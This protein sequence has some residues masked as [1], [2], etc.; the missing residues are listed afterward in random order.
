MPL[1]AE[2]APGRIAILSQ[3]GGVGAMMLNFLAMEHLGFSK[4]ASIGNKLNVNEVDLLEYL[5]G[6]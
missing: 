1:K 4:F 6:D 2:A 5:I 3:S